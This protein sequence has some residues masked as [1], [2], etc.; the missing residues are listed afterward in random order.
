M[1]APA[2]VRLDGDRSV[3][4]TRRFAAPRALVWRAFTEPALL[5][6]WLL[7]P[8]GW[9]MHVCEVDARTGGSYRWRWRNATT[10][11]EFGF[12]GTYSKVVDKSHL[13]DT[14]SFDAGTTRA[15][16]GTASNTADFTDDGSATRVV[17]R[18]TYPDAATLKAALATGMTDGMEM[19]YARLDQLIPTL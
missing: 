5:T 6:R 15:T 3:I 13:A 4:V 19:S 11:E 9:E 18:I 7:G 12:A 17:T 10:E 1:P 16:M 14:Q 8:P 2:T